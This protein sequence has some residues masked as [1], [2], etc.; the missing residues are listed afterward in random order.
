MQTKQL[1]NALALNPIIAAIKD[2]D[3]LEAALQTDVEVIFVLHSDIF[4]IKEISGKIKASGKIGF[5]HFNFV[6]GLSDEDI[7]L[8]YIRENTDFDGII[9]T[10]AN[11]ISAAK[12][13]GFFTIQ[14]LF[15]L[16]SMSLENI[17]SQV[18]MKHSDLIE[19]LPNVNKKII[20][21]VRQKIK[22]PLLVSGLILD[23]EDVM[24]ALANGA[25]AISSTNH[26]V[27][28]L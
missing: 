26:S 28:E 12:A 21:I 2:M 22:R 17:H 4:N 24:N 14:R 15:L 10:K 16:D 13:L 23:K 18:Q 5:L 1:F 20:H 27:W 9:S 25:A 3:D 6:K 19:I 8:K 7:S 11:H